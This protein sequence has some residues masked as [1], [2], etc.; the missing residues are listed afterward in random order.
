MAATGPKA[1]KQD[2]DDVDIYTDLSHNDDELANELFDA[3]LSGSMDESKKAITEVVPSKV[4]PIKAAPTKLT[5]SKEKAEPCVAKKN[6]SGNSA[7]KLSI[8]VG[9][10]PWWVSD[11]DLIFMAQQLGVKDVTDVKFAE[12]KV[13]GQ[14]RGYA[15]MTV[16]SQESLKTLLDKIPECKLNGMPLRVQS[17]DSKESESSGGP[18][19]FSPEPVPPPAPL[20]SPFPPLPN[21]FLAQPPPHLFPHFPPNIPPP[22]LPPPLF[23]PPPIHSPCQPSGLHLNPPTVSAGNGGQSSEPYNQALQIPET[24]FE[25]LMNRNKAVASTAITKAVSGATAGNVQTAMETLLAAIAII[26]QSR[27]YQ[28]ERCQ[29][30]VTS[31]KDCLVS[32]NGNNSLRSESRSRDEERDRGRDRERRRDRDRD[33]ED[34]C[35]W[36]G[37]GT[38]RRRRDRSWSGDRERD[39]DRDRDRHR[40]HRDRYH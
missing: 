20:P 34:S 30:L 36:E 10:F 16:S 24:D 3:V 11:L 18:S 37:A 6:T 19:F 8:Y 12:N 13:N 28:D 15:E 7:R 17:K 1:L 38:S 39:R 29:A 4:T 5:Q 14:S 27:V 33:R 40:Y 23:P 2:V 22:P 21:P 26:K 9:N 35:V 32:I 25:E 31:L